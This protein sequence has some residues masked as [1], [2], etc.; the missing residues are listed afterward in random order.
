MEEI[1]ERFSRLAL[2]M[3]RMECGKE[4]RR[5]Q[6]EAAVGSLMQR[7]VER[8]VRAL[9]ALGGKLQGHRGLA[10]EGRLV[11]Q[12][13]EGADAVEKASGARRLD[14]VDVLAQ[15][16]GLR[17]K[18]P[19]VAEAEREALLFPDGIDFGCAAACHR[20]HQAV[21]QQAD[22]DAPALARGLVAAGLREG[23]DGAEPPEA[24]VVGEQELAAP[25][26]AVGA[27]ARAVER[28]ADDGRLLVVL[29]HAGEDV[30]VVV[31]DFE[32][33]HAG[34]L[35]ERFG[36]GRSVVA[37]VQVAGD[38]LRAVLEQGFHE[39]D[40]ILEREHGA[41]VAHVADVRR[42]VEEVAAREA[43][44]VL[45]LA[46]DAEHLPFEWGAEH[47]G[48]RGEAA[49]AAHH[50]G[51]ARKPVHDG[52]VGAQADA[53]VVREDHVAERRERLLGLLVIVADRRARGIAARH[54][55]H[56]GDFGRLM[57]FGVVEDQHLHG[58][59]GQHDADLWVA[60]RDARRERAVLA[61]AQQQ[62]GLL[63]ARHHLSFAR[64]EVAG[65]ARRLL[66]AH[67]DGKGLLR[68][69]LECA[70]TVDG[71]FICRVAGEV[72]AADALDGRDAA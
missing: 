28:D 40:G 46:A 21:P 19:L 59:V 38:G 67:H 49:A 25:D 63:V 14:A 12:A 33:R 37:R 17:Q 8:T 23:L 11:P 57:V 48:Q 50:V 9:R 3:A 35:G 53:A 51:P 55:E 24:L 31:L 34:L 7:Q 44:G 30:R 22:G 60:R 4:C 2:L 58:R 72:E 43:E 52:V 26:R 39:L 71:R 10:L 36:D 41:Q 70:Q 68:A 20:A 27:V 65:A 47:E 62:D 15:H 32:E 45:E 66:V 16:E 18:F 1:G 61:A 6:Q 29:G 69:V 5:R 42:R 56:G 13:Q 54:D 64:L